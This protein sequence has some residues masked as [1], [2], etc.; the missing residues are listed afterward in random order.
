MG[1]H[2]LS[3]RGEPPLPAYK[4]TRTHGAA[5]PFATLPRRID[6]MAATTPPPSLTKDD[7]DAYISSGGEDATIY[8]AAGRSWDIVPVQFPPNEYS[9]SGNSDEYKS[10]A[11][12]QEL[13]ASN[14]SFKR[15]RWNGP[16]R[17]INGGA[18]VVPQLGTRFSCKDAPFYG[19]YDAYMQPTRIFFYLVP[20]PFGK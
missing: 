4:T 19:Y 12:A 16:Y 20:T 5:P 3:A 9:P 6:I 13:L 7:F 8:D 15:S 18:P 11:W 10:G 17:V 2:R 1:G 14:L